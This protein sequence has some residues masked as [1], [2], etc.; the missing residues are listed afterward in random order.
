MRQ[1]RSLSSCG[2]EMHGVGACTAGDAVR[3][4]RSLELGL[5]LDPAAPA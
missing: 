1:Q 3:S 4:S 2:G 5:Y